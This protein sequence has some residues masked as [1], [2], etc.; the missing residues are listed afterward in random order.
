MVGDVDLQ[1]VIRDIGGA[2]FFST[3][4]LCLDQLYVCVCY[5]MFDDER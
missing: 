4:V 5:G 3:M 2:N 1:V